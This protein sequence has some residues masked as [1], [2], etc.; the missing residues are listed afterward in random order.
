M[1]TRSEVIVLILNINILNY[2]IDKLTKA[3]YNTIR[4]LC[5]KD[6]WRSLFCAVLVLSLA[7]ATIFPGYSLDVGR[8]SGEIRLEIASFDKDTIRISAILAD[9]AALC[10]L[11][12]CL[13]YDSETLELVYAKNST[14]EG[15]YFLFAD[16]G[17]SV[18]FILD[19]DGNV[20]SDVVAEFSFRTKRG[21]EKS[22]IEFEIIPIEAYRW[23]YDRLLEVDLIGDRLFAPGY[24]CNGVA[25]LTNATV[26]ARNKDTY[27]LLEGRVENGCAAAGFEVTVLEEGSARG[28]SY[29]LIS[30]MPRSGEGPSVF[31]KEIK[32]SQKGIACVAVC[33]L[34][35]KGREIAKGECEVFVFSRGVLSDRF[36]VAH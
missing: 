14:G 33:P 36:V 31:S 29:R 12:A 10:G 25:F 20:F 2:C 17:G 7:L 32:I 21:S 23:E 4:F 11:G 34:A 15:A 28:E 5:K 8:I 24:F 9:G 16:K 35:Y 27:L 6:Q 18:E 26:F 1:I 19:G 22:L 3:I 13:R 30:A